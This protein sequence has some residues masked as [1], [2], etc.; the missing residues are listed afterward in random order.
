MSNLKTL[1]PLLI[2]LVGI[3]IGFALS[4][5]PSIASQPI[6][7]II[8]NKEIQSDPPPQIIND[9]V[10]VPICVV[11]ENLGASVEWDGENRI[12]RIYSQ[13]PDTN[14]VNTSSTLTIR[15]IINKKHQY[16]FDPKSWSGKIYL[17]DAD[18]AYYKTVTANS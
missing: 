2:L 4:P 10:F 15:D 8:N 7:L 12:V 14:N 11:S 6:K 16:S 1:K 5:Y 9:R 13:K 17:D 3:F 18:I